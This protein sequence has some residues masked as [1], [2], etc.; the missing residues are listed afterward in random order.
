MI[1]IQN[2][3]INSN[4]FTLIIFL[5]A[6]YISPSFSSGEVIDRIVAIVNDAP[7]TL[8]DVN[9]EI[10]LMRNDIP[11]R[12][13]NNSDEEKMKYLQGKA[14]DN[15][16]DEQLELQEAKEKGISISDET[17]KFA[18]A[19]QKEAFGMSDYDLEK[20]LKSENISM[21][22]YKE[23]IRKQL[24]LIS[25][26]NN[27]VKPKI[28]ITSSEIIN[29]YNENIG[30]FTEEGEVT[31]AQLVIIKPD[32]N[33]DYKEF[34]RSKLD[35]VLV[36]AQNGISL[37]ELEQTYTSDFPFIKYQYLGN[38][39]KNDLAEGF[40]D[41]FSMKQNEC[42]LVETGDGY[43]ILKLLN[44]KSDSLKPFSE[45]S[46]KIKEILYAEKSEKILKNFI[47]SLREK[48]YIEKRLL[49][50]PLIR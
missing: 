43:H 47:E 31:L 36:K 18:I 16:I 40:Q 33:K 41:A 9:K 22:E 3:K 34:D 13:K 5:M 49:D 8:N 7:I 42:S 17:I 15:L 37:E 50:I 21:D 19:D 25:L 6:F 44:R 14:V 48:A 24:I 38:F 1:Y 39:K 4:V 11:E 30:F 35:E 20:S 10:V 12:L 23:K 26:M 46:E 45:A 27:A 28:N 32:F 2:K 29:Y